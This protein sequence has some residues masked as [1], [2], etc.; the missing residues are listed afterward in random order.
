MVSSLF[1]YKQGFHIA[2]AELLHV[3]DLASDSKN[4]S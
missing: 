1:Y 2:R 4:A 3:S